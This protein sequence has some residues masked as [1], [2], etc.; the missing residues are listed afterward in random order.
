[1]NKSIFKIVI[2]LGAIIHWIGVVIG[3]T[4]P[5]IL[6]EEFGIHYSQEFHK[7]ILHLALF[8]LVVAVFYSLSAFWAFKNKIE[9]FQIGIVIGVVTIVCF[10]I[11]LLLIG[12]EIDYLLLAM[13][14]L[15]TLTGYLAFKQ[16]NG[17]NT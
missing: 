3:L 14:V 17:K 4:N 15:T 1:M 16:S 5:K 7:L 8:F 12:K 11:D 10:V 13:G 6:A 9:G 2:S